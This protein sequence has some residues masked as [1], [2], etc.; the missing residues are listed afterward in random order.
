[1]DWHKRGEKIGKLLQ[2]FK[3]LIC[4]INVYSFLKLKPTSAQDSIKITIT[5]QHASGHMFIAPLVVHIR[6]RTQ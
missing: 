5:L 2:H 4:I 3:M 1:M 6:G